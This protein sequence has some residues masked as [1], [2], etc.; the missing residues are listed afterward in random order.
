MIYFKQSKGFYLKPGGTQRAVSERICDEVGQRSWC[1]CTKSYVICVLVLHLAAHTHG[2]PF[3]RRC[4]KN[5]TVASCDYEKTAKKFTK[6]KFDKVW[7]W[8]EMIWIVWYN[9]FFASFY[10][11]LLFKLGSLPKRKKWLLYLNNSEN[12]PGK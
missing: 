6:W 7:K 12:V 3:I 5:Q 10:S 8:N 11:V 1:M 9:I 2:V 4:S